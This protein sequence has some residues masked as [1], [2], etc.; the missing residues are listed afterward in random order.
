M[1]QL[2]YDKGE[3]KLDN[4]LI[5]I[6]KK[7]KL[8]TADV[9]RIMKKSDEFVRYGLINNKFSFGFAIKL[10]KRDKYN[11][12]INPKKFWEYMGEDDISN[13]ENLDKLDNFYL[14]EGIFIL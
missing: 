4:N 1:S 6:K 7:N 5:D 11:Y 12:Y 3:L 8:T 2:G 14:D 13:K 10:P 9:A